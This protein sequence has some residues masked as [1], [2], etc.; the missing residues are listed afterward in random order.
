MKAASSVPFAKPVNMRSSSV[1]Q[2]SWIDRSY[3]VRANGRIGRC[4]G[5]LIGVES[6]F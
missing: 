1:K 2:R 3:G 4:K 5:I 6:Q